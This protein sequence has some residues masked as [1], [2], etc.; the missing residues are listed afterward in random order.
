MQAEFEKEMAPKN[1]A[2]EWGETPKEKL[3]RQL[4]EQWRVNV[5]PGASTS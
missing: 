4:I 2:E 3:K 1:P 5:V